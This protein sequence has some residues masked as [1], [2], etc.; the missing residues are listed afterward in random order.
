MIDDL[1]YN[2][3]FRDLSHLFSMPL[4][5]S[6]TTDNFFAIAAIPAFGFADYFNS[7]VMLLTPCGSTVPGSYGNRGA[8][9]SITFD[10][11]DQGLLN[12]VFRHRIGSMVLC[13]V[14]P[15]IFFVPA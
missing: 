6:S 9:T 7:G 4:S 15:V 10:G 1:V 13:P 11:A 14:M 8:Q 2:D 5:I 12:M 3:R